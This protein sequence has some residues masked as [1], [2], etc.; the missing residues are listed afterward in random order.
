MDSLTTLQSSV[1]YVPTGLPIEDWL[2]SL[3]QGSRASHIPMQEEEKE[4]QT[5]E[6]SG[7]IPDGAL[8]KWD[9]DTSCWRTFQASFLTGMQ[10]LSP[11]NFPNSGTMQC[12]VLYQQ[13]MSGH[14]I[15]G[16]GGG[17]LGSWPT[18]TVSD[19]EGGL[20]RNVEMKNGSFSRENKDGVRWG[21][22]LRDATENWPTPTANEDAAGTPSGKMQKMLGNHPQL[23]A[24]SSP[25]YLY[26][27][28]AP[29]ILTNGDSSSENDQTSPRR[30]RKRLNAAFAEWMMGLPIGWTDLRPLETESYQQWLQNFLGG[31]SDDES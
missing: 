17:A 13:Q 1:I 3:P 21:V 14:R 26:G 10:E 6:T 29:Q 25:S 24:L 23:R 4:K 19:T 15:L 16:R 27:R 12:G 22:K 5:T 8:A 18:P 11:E 9:H 30:L 20:V 2:T 31:V 28:Q 7:P